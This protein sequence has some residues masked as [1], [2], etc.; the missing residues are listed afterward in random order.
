MPNRRIDV[1]AVI[2]KIRIKERAGDPA[3]PSSGYG[4]IY[5]KSD[6]LLYLM[7]DGGN[8]VSLAAET[9][10]RYFTLTVSGDLTVDPGVLRLYNLT[11][12]A[13]TISKVHLAVNTAPT[14]ADILVDVNEDGTTIFTNQ[15]NRPTVAI[16]AFTGETTT[17]D[18]ASWADGNYIQVDVDQIGST[19]AGSDLTVT[20]VAS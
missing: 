18:D 12:A 10:E 1:D 19:I 20:V 5:E 17:I 2:D 6:G 8:V 9:V 7:D 15:A 14:G 3:T 11:G 13:L 16:S 4:W